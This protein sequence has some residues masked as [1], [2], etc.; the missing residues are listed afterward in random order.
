MT[1]YLKFIRIYINTISYIFPKYAGRLSFKLFETTRKH[2]IKDREKSF[3]EKA[4][5]FRV[6]F[7]Q[8]D[9][10]CYEMGDPKGK[11]VLLVHGW[12]SNAGSLSRF[13]LELANKNYRVISF[14]L[15]AH[16]N[17]KLKRTNLLI[18]KNALTALVKF[19]N[20]QQPF[21]IIT[22]S[23]GSALSNH[24]LPEMNYAIDKMI[25]LTAN[26][27]FEPVFLDFK[28]AIGFNDIVYNQFSKL[29]CEKLGEK[30]EDMDLSKKIP[31][32]DYKKILIIH[33]KFDKVLRFH[34]GEELH[35][36]LPRTTLSAYEK[37]GHYRMLWNE[38]V[39]KETIS[40]MES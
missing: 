7:D 11:L 20:P 19:I 12:D 13:A 3:Y 5:H 29:V 18:C 1:L 21:S 36:L 16:A 14:D 17:S 23:F 33:D 32:I 27:N 35:E 25:L 10:H 30:L 37:I 39:V 40:F 9:L 22:H 6:S 31:K 26:N 4:Q 34:N 15:P 2:P 24:S 38:D 28:K 8:E